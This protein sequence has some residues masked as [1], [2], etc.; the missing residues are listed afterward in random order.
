M[1]GLARPRR[2]IKSGS[3]RRV[4]PRL[5][6]S[7]HAVSVVIPWS[8][9]PTVPDLPRGEAAIFVAIDRLPSCRCGPEF[10]Y[11][12]RCG[13]APPTRATRHRYLVEITVNTRLGGARPKRLL[14]VITGRDH[15]KIPSY[16]RYSDRAFIGGNRSANGCSPDASSSK[17]KGV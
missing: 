5:V 12:E 15:A 3:Y 10:P 2:S 7:V 16:G 4:Q 1:S 17:A 8:T 6:A 14:A 11:L 9:A 13:K